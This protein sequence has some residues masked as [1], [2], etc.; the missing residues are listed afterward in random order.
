MKTYQWAIH[1]E[2]LQEQTKEFQPG[3]EDFLY[4][5]GSA[6]N[7]VAKDHKE[8]EKNSPANPRPSNLD[9]NQYPTGNRKET[10][11]KSINWKM[12]KAPN[13]RGSKMKTNSISYRKRNANSLSEIGTKSPRQME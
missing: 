3:V 11:L 10:S 4:L 6:Y 2:N 1:Q 5:Q 13:I 12:C 8:S 9:F 7:E